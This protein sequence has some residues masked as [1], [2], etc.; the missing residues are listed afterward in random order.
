MIT[1]MV[2]MT[3][4]SASCCTS[5]DESE[6]D[7]GGACLDFILGCRALLFSSCSGFGGYHHVCYVFLFLFSRVSGFLPFYAY[8]LES[9]R[10]MH[11]ICIRHDI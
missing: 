2:R 6:S 9:C 4:T 1:T 3:S 11:V 8:L 10:V 5:R 7:L